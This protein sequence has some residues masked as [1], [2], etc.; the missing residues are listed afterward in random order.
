[1]SP[2][3]CRGKSRRSAA[4]VG[5]CLCSL[6]LFHKYCRPS[7]P[8]LSKRVG[9]HWL[10]GSFKIETNMFIMIQF[11]MMLNMKKT[12]DHAHDPCSL[13]WW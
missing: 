12:Q 4:F 9:Q 3:A 6:A 11:T 10:R 1:M 8:P 7:D 5:K 13:N 2:F